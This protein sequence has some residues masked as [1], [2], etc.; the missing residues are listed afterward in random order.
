MLFIFYSTNDFLLIITIN[1][2]QIVFVF[3]NNYWKIQAR[4]SGS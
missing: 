3:A 4:N 1:A 2:I